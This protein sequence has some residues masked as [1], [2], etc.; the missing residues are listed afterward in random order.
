METPQLR[1]K[2]KYVNRTAFFKTQ[3]GTEI[4]F[5]GTRMYTQEQL[6]SFYQDK[7]LNKVVEIYTK[8]KPTTANTRKFPFRAQV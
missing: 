6:Q 4:F 7:T 2:E 5:D 8:P 3:R 1:I